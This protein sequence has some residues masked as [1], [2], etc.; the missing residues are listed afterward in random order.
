MDPSRDTPAEWP[1]GAWPPGARPRARPWQRAL[2]LIVAAL[3]VAAPALLFWRARVRRPPAPRVLRWTPLRLVAALGVPATAAAPGPR[4]TLAV[5]TREGGVL[6][7]DLEG[8]AP[9]WLLRAEAAA[10]LLDGPVTALAF[11]A[12]GERLLAAGGHAITWWQLDPPRLLGQ[13]RGPQIITAAVLAPG[14]RAAFF[15]TDQ[16]F[17]QRWRFDRREAEA[18]LRLGCELIVLEY[19]RARLPLARR[20]PF[21]TF[22]QT[23]ELRPACAYP[24]TQLVR[25]GATLAQ[26]CR[27]GT[28]SVIPLPRGPVQHTLAGALGA[29]AFD[30]R[31]RLLLAREDGELRLYDPATRAVERAWPQ[32]GRAQALATADD[33][34]ALADADGTLRLWDLRAAGEALPAATLRLPAPPVWL[35]LDRRPLRLR[36]LLAD[37]RL[38]EV[39]GR[40]AGASL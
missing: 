27:T 22:V 33:L 20:C 2:L 34:A 19:Q 1:S 5:G 17:V 6:L 24:V 18:A 3:L 39:A 29:L 38:V 31:G 15:G 23:H 36:A 8:H 11:S 30:P 28:T 16:G 13:L 7:A 26:A 9:R 32:A 21:G 40:S 12:D 10:P 37:G 35:S 25:Q 14:D 4:G